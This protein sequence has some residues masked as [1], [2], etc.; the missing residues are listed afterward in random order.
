MVEGQDEA[1]REENCMIGQGKEEESV[2]GGGG[3]NW[4]SRTMLCIHK[5][6][7]ARR[8]RRKETGNIDYLSSSPFLIIS[9]LPPSSAPTSLVL[10]SF[11]SPYPPF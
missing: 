8:N 11:C 1:K 7:E 5:E 10:P 2:E 6:H 3:F 9:R 4:A